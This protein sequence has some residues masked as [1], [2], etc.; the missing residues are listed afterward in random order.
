MTQFDQN[1]PYDV[2]LSFAGED[3]NYADALANILQGEGVKVFYDKYEKAILWGQ[4]LY[5]YLSD[6]YQH[7][8]GFSQKAR[9]AHVE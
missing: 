4:D 7:Q 2:A 9:K 8:Q 1:Y 3:R 6:I 5:S